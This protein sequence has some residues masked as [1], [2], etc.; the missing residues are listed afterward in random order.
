LPELRDRTRGAS[1][2]V[3]SAMAT[4]NARMIAA[5]LAGSVGWPP[6]IELP[7][8]EASHRELGGVSGRLADQ[9]LA[10]SRRRGEAGGDVDRVPERGEFNVLGGGHRADVCG[11]G[12]RQSMRRSVTWDRGDGS[13][14]S[15]A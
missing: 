10:A 1:T 14:V 7:V 8:F 6:Q 13:G 4:G 15:D 2:P 5:M 11:V 9:E 3:A 12:P